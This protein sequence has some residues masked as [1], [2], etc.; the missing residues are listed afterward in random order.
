MFGMDSHLC[1]VYST[2]IHF[3]TYSRTLEERKETT[4]K[5]GA[6]QTILCDG[7]G[8]AG[9]S[10]AGTSCTAAAVLSAVVRYMRELERPL[11][12]LTYTVGEV[13]HLYVQSDTCAIS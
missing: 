12:L 6:I 2:D 3:R 8:R 7:R 10:A 11:Q 1:V 9:R 5:A 4:S 13:G